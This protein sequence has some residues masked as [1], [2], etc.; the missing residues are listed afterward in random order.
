MVG[1]YAPFKDLI[2]KEYIDWMTER[3]PGGITE[4]SLTRMASGFLQDASA[5][6][7]RGDT[8]EYLRL[9]K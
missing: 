9:I 4:V 1:K 7:A 2:L 6:L 3:V 8:G 5:A